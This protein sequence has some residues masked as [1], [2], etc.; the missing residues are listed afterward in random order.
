MITNSRKHVIGINEL[1]CKK[2]GRNAFLSQIV[3]ISISMTVSPG[4]FD[5]QC[6]YIHV[7][8]QDPKVENAA[9]EALLLYSLT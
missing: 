3:K 1:V 8:T 9:D 6:L 2:F 5:F 4:K 7:M